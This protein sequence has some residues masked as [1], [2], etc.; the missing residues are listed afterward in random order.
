MRETTDGG[1][2]YG[3]IAYPRRDLLQGSENSTF[4]KTSTSKT[5]QALHLLAINLLPSLK[6][7]HA[8][9]GFFAEEFRE[10]YAHS[11]KFPSVKNMKKASHFCIRR[12][13]RWDALPCLPEA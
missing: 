12:M 6:F 9:G 2:F 10:N 4:V 8:I 11:Q 7:C 13:L 1:E 5:P 3:S